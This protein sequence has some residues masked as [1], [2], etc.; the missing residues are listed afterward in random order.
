[1]FQK[2]LFSFPVETEGIRG[3]SVYIYIYIYIHTH[4]FNLLYFL[5]FIPETNIASG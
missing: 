1:M 5:F 3:A 2:R 4:T